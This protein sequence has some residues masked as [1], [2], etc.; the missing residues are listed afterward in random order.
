MPQ[1][2]RKAK[3][4]ATR[5]RAAGLRTRPMPQPMASP[6]P[7]VEPKPAPAPERQIARQSAPT[8]QYDYSYVFADLRRI[9]LLSGLSFGIMILLA[10]IIR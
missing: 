10:L 6:A 7:D 2:S 8:F 9:A 1:K 3:E 4:R 5:R